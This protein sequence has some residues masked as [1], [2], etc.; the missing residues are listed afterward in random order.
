MSKIE[1]GKFVLTFAEFN[2]EKTLQ[3]AINVTGFRIE[4]KK[5][6]F[7]LY[8]DSD[9]PAFLYGD[10]QRL[11]QVI[12]NLLTNA[13]KFTPENGCV[14]L[15]AHFVSETNG[16]CTIKVEVKDTGIGLSE[17]QKSRLFTSFEQAET[18]ISRKFGGTGLGLAICKRI[19]EL[20]GGE[21]WAE[22]ELGKGS[23][24]GFTIKLGCGMNKYPAKSDTVKSTGE[25]TTE[26]TLEEI[27]SFKGC[28]LLLAE[29]NEINREIVIS[30]LE[31]SELTIDCAVNGI[32]AVNMFA[33]SPDS[34]D[35]IFMDMQM[36]QMDGLEATRQ[37]RRLDLPH[38]KDIPI[39]AMTANV[40]KEDIDKCLDAGMNAH[41][42]KPLDFNEVMEVLKRY[43][44]QNR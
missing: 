23:T 26:G 42:G 33:S 20:M 6:Q 32:E 36:P 25:G 40:F 13:V 19:V 21:I 10:D 37:I 12:T 44:A 3:K 4:E 34:Y 9:I 16:I 27:Q 43:L 18:S 39:V 22:S 1:A 7:S 30:L 17:D 24:F 38:A 14:W 15:K 2:F 5:Q 8:L 11:T 31:T 29:D 41:I 35:L 28:R